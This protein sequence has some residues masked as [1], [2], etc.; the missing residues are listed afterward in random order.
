MVFISTALVVGLAGTDRKNILLGFGSIL[1]FMLNLPLFL[2]KYFRFFKWGVTNDAKKL[3]I[4]KKSIGPIRKDL[5][6]LNFSNLTL[7][8]Q[9]ASAFYSNIQEIIGPCY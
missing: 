8:V 3:I 2:L 4:K 7:D 5:S 6:V 1:S 9:K